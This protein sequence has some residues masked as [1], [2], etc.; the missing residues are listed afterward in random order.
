MK[1]RFSTLAML[2]VVTLLGITPF[3]R[4]EE[5]TKEQLIFNSA[6]D[7]AKQPVLHPTPLTPEALEALA[8]DQIVG[9]CLK[10]TGISADQAFA[11]FVASEI[12]LGG[13]DET[14]FVVLP[15]LLLK[16]GQPGDVPDRGC[17][18]GANAAWFWALRSTKQGY[19]LIFSG[20][21]QYLS[22]LRHRTNGFRNVKT[23]VIFQEGR[24]M[25][26]AVYRF[27]GQAYVKV[28]VKELGGD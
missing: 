15:S 24:T 3:G 5:G 12:H 4:A 25:D 8:T 16:A 2:I 18:L 10:E 22:V 1:D 17:F 21:G 26:E 19:R 20:G 27:D 14:D 11:W 6:Q 28:K 13:R 7:Y 23:S 9:G